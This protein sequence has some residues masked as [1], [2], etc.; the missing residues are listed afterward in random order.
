M[1]TAT[2]VILLLIGGYF[3]GMTITYIVCHL[4][5]GGKPEDRL[6]VYEGWK[7]GDAGIM[8]AVWPITLLYQCV[9]LAGERVA[10]LIDKRP[11]GAVKATV[12]RSGQDSG[13]YE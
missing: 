7:G 13:L 6:T 4:R 1:L 11:H 8:L 5:H 3:G 12:L 10:S 2:V 9:T